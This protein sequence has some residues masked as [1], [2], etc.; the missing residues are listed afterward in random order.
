MAKLPT[1]EIYSALS[2]SRRN[3]EIDDGTA[4]GLKEKTAEEFG[5]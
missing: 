4:L 2:L 3:S 5:E 1:D